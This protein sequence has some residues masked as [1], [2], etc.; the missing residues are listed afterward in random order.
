MMRACSVRTVG[1]IEAEAGKIP[2]PV[3][4]LRVS[5]AVI[6]RLAQLDPPE[7]R[8]VVRAMARVGREDGRPFP[9]EG[10]HDYMVLV[11]QDS[12]TAPVVVYRRVDGAR[13]EPDGWRVISLLDRSDYNAVRKWQRTVVT[14]ALAGGLAAP[15]LAGIGLPLAPLAA[16]GL[17]GAV[18]SREMVQRRAMERILRD[19]LSDAAAAGVEAGLAAGLA[20]HQGAED[21]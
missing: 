1:S 5:Q 14:G 9:L 11:P 7:R 3:Q 2:P 10:E 21:D 19:A 16:A 18:N 20:A 6:D 17:V 12:T 13:D 8:A 4:G 15:I